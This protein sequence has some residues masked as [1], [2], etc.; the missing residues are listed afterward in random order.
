MDMGSNIAQFLE[1]Q[2]PL[3]TRFYPGKEMRMLRFPGKGPECP[4]FS[5]KNTLML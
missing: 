1:F 4:S 5:F 2:V 3:P